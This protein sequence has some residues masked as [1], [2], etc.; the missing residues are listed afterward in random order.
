MVKFPIGLLQSKIIV[1]ESLKEKLP[2]LFQ[3]ENKHIMSKLVYKK[4]VF[5][6]WINLLL[7][8]SCVLLKFCLTMLP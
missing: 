7:F 6:Q 2:S 5:A 1:G 3:N 4:N 8:I